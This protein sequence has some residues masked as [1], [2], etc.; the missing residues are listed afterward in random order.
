VFA[1]DK[2]NAPDS[3]FKALPIACAAFVAVCIAF[4]QIIPNSVNIIVCVDYTP[5]IVP[6]AQHADRAVLIIARV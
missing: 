3:A 1:F 2:L 6:L 4:H 5:D